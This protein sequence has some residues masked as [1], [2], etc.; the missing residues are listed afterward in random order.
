MLRQA[1]RH[2]AEIAGHGPAPTTSS[3]SSSRVD[4][5]GDKEGAD[6]RLSGVW[7]VDFGREAPERQPNVL[8]CLL[9]PRSTRATR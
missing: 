8:R 4:G 9:Q 5:R 2:V 1:C 6:D 7:V 3:R